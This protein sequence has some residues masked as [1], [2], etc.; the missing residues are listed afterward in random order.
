MI[1][2]KLTITDLMSDLVKR[3]GSDLHLTADSVPYF[4][5][6][7]S[8]IPASNNIYKEETLVSD[9][10]SILG[11]EKLRLFFEEKELDCSYGLE[12]VAR[13]R[14][15]IFLDR[16]KISCVMRAL[17]TDIPSFSQ[18]G[19]PDS[20]QQLLQRPRGL[21]LVTGPTGSGKTTTLA[22]SID[23]INANNAHHILTI[24]DPIEFVFENKNCL[25]R[26]REVG[27]DTP[28]NEPES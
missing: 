10:K 23:W 14:L 22:S 17:S 18:I 28:I 12:G 20:V 4:R 21:M 24:E 6:Q 2:Q 9:L 3:Q 13:F 5:I 25:V 26:Q 11:P 27:E 1:T 8:I 16:G 19:L 7:G 15:N